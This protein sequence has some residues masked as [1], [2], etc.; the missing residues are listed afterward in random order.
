MIQQPTINLRVARVVKDLDPGTQA[1]IEANEGEELYFRALSEEGV[2][3]V[4]NDAPRDGPYTEELMSKTLGFAIVDPM[5]RVHKKF[6]SLEAA[7]A[8]KNNAKINFDVTVDV[9]GDNNAQE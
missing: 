9:Q 3:L 2:Y 7:E 5:G 4:D 6:R 8:A 1:E